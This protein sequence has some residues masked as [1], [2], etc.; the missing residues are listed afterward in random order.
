[1]RHAWMAILLFLAAP[2]AH[3]QPYLG[4]G[5]IVAERQNQSANDQDFGFGRMVLAFDDTLIVGAAGHMGH[6]G[7]MFVY[8][9]EAGVWVERQRVAHPHD[10]NLGWFGHQNGFGFSIVR[11][12]NRLLVGAPFTVT[13]DEQDAGAVFV[14]ERDDATGLWAVERRFSAPSPAASGQ[15]GYALAFSG[16][17]LFVG[18][19]S[20]TPPLV[21]ESIADISR[22]GRV[23]AYIR[24]TGTGDWVLITTLEAGVDGDRFGAAIAVAG[25]A[26]VV[27]APGGSGAVHWYD[28]AGGAPVAVDSFTDPD[29]GRSF[30][31][32][33]SLHGNW[34]LVGGA[35]GAVGSS[36]NPLSSGIAQLFVLDGGS[37]TMLATFE[38]GEADDGFGSSVLLLDDGHALVG[39]PGSGVLHLY[40][41]AERWSRVQRVTEPIQSIFSPAGFGE[42]LARIDDWV[43][44]G[45]PVSLHHMGLLPSFLRG[46]HMVEIPIVGPPLVDLELDLQHPSTVSFGDQFEV[47]YEVTNRSATPALAAFVNIF[48][49]RSDYFISDPVD[50]EIPEDCYELRA[51]VFRCELGAIEPGAT[52]GVTITHRYARD[53]MFQ[54]SRFRVDTYAGSERADPDTTNNESVVSVALLAPPVAPPVAPQVPHDGG[55]GRM[56]ALSVAA[57]ALLLAASLRLRNGSGRRIRA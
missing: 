9:R 3:G 44:A 36:V 2:A 28:I 29:G 20:G 57:W 41:E 50:T 53:P 11:A 12:G 47:R 1:M 8:G 6:R 43:Y 32:A 21:D 25:D 26:L 19:P 51:A 37:L 35:S 10:P 23:F 7:S 42:V 5:E 54:N 18:Q 34:L 15:F 17:T 46:G 48:R 14:L 27:G 55:G 33:L 22:P 24:D 52:V 38:S 16:D 40:S 49:R 56:D 30:G 31:R 39:A 13:D 4:F 45:A